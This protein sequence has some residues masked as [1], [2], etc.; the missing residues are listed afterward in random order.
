MYVAAAVC[1]WFLRSWKLGQIERI[2]AEQN[3]RPEDIDTV[4]VAQ[5]DDQAVSFV[6]RNYESGMLRRLFLWKKV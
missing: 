6:A 4:S 1:M 2:A 5:M 3:K